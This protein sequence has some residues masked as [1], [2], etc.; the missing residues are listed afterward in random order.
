MAGRADDVLPRRHVRM[1]CR[2]R[3]R[4]WRRRYGEGLPERMRIG[5][6][7]REPFAVIERARVAGRVTVQASLAVV[8]HRRSREV[9]VAVV[10]APHG[11]RAERGMDLIDVLTEGTAWRM[12][13][14]AGLLREIRGGDNPAAR[15]LDAG[16]RPGHRVAGRALLA[17]V[18][19]C[20]RVVAPGGD[21]D[22]VER[23][24]GTHLG[25]GVGLW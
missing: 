23:V 7:D 13:G 9:P 21:L 14:S 22:A 3:Q 11:D 18:R 16:D 24:V 2:A 10:D 1:A 20:G 5:A 25:R 12:A 6:G 8:G 15:S 19:I 17:G 4:D